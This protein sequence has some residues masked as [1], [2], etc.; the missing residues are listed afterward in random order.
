MA[1]AAATVSMRTAG[2]PVAAGALEMAS[3]RTLA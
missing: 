1:S 2:I 3:S